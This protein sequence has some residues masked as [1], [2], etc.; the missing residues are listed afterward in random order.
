M[1]STENDD[2]DQSEA[3]VSN[4]WKKLTFWVGATVGRDTS[5]LDGLTKLEAFHKFSIRTRG[6]R[7][8]YEY[9]DFFGFR[10]IC[11][12]R[13]FEGRSALL[14]RLGSTKRQKCDDQP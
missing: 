2:D 6:W 11:R 7:L 14:L 5:P 12:W 3:I 8:G 9:W 1:V 4:L 10:E 13:G